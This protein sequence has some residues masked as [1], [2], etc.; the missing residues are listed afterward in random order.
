MNK[1]QSGD[2]AKNEIPDRVQDAKSNGTNNGRT[3]KISDIFENMTDG[4]VLC[5]V[6][7]NLES[8]Q[9]DFIFID[10]NPAFLKL[11]GLD[12][13]EIIGNTAKELIQKQDSEFIGWIIKLGNI[14]VT[15][16]KQRT[17]ENFSKCLK[18]WFLCRN[19]FTKQGQLV[20]SF[21]DITI[22]K[23]S[24]I[25]LEKS[26]KKYQNIISNLMEGFYAVTTEGILI[27]Y[28]LEFCKILGLDPN[29]NQKGI[30]VPN[31]WREVED[32]D[33][34]LTQLM[35][36]GFIQNYKVNGKKLNG[37]LVIFEVN[38]RII[39]DESGNPERIEGTFLDV[40]A[41]ENAITALRENEEKYRLLFENMNEGFLLH[42]IIADKH[43]NDFNFLEMNPACERIMGINRTRTLGQRISEITQEFPW[44]EICQRV[45][46]N[47][48]S[49]SIEKYSPTL[50]K[51]FRIS[52]FQPKPGQVAAIFSDVTSKKRTEEELKKNQERLQFALSGSGVSYWEWFAETG[53]IFFDDSWAERLGYSAKER[54]FNYTWWTENL[55]PE[56]VPIAKKAIKDYVTGKNTRYELEYRMKTKTGEW[57]WVW[58][59]GICVEWEGKKPLRFLG[60]HKDITESKRIEEDLHKS[61]HNLL[62][63]QRIA[64]IG[65][66]TW[67]SDND[68]V[69]C[70]NE[71]IRILG[72]QPGK[73]ALKLAQIMKQIHPD[74]QKHVQTKLQESIEKG[75]PYDTQFRI[76]WDDE[77]IHF[78]HGI[79]QVRPSE[80]GKTRLLSGVGQDITEQKKA[81]NALK[82]SESLLNEVGKIA[83]IGGWEFNPDTGAGTWTAET[84]RIHDLDPKEPTSAQKGLTFYPPFYKERIEKAIGEAI[85]K[86]IPWDVELVLISAK[87]I[88]KWVRSIGHP[89]IKDDKVIKLTG[90]F[91]DITERKEIEEEL[92]KHQ[93]RLEE[94]VKERTIE[95][96]EK[97]EELR[98]S[99]YKLAEVNQAL[100]SFTYSVSHDLRAPLRHIGGFAK[101]LQN[102]LEK[103]I[104]DPKYYFSKIF[105]ASKRM[106]EMIDDLLGFSRIGRS[107]LVKTDIDLNKL[108]AE[109]ITEMKTEIQDRKINWQI[110]NLPVVQGDLNLFKLVFEN[111]ITNAVK[112]TIYK[113]EAQIEIGY[114]KLNDQS[115]ELYIKDNGAGF[116]SDYSHKLFNVFQRLHSD[117]EFEGT[118]IGLANVKK[119]IERHGGAVRATGKTNEG[120]TFFL[121]LPAKEK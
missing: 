1:S 89:T 53:E 21:I 23:K 52:A 78:I 84:A 45:A 91:Q 93:E 6:I 100:E 112:F 120:A 63:A 79:G 30:K 27:E 26:K 44:T 65:S 3:N 71:M 117:D 11:L 67:N 62:E 58:A 69:I 111:L 61:E 83:K 7:P 115:I 36:N 94:L 98:Q 54:D 119:I 20:F 64:H 99:N 10:T 19:F 39:K 37:E 116:D 114:N 33:K 86:K 92:I 101:L 48:K 76:V 40:T 35:Q 42:E 9:N 72:Y 96:E 70:S 82:E 29:K 51:W 13:N 74:D 43:S 113:E 5:E 17:V 8:N 95:L 108:I 75:I 46:V 118:G 90:S 81:E 80:D 12:Y 18:Q 47:G 97:N 104:K 66:W 24:D 15:E 105:E 25:K 41:R 57:I 68:E 28:N 34:Y 38:A 50:N 14:A 106:Q 110:T 2:N 102:E 103:P 107:E 88:R 31:F 32:R 16:K 109:I 85:T 4:F 121:I 87:G 60:T 22:L 56:S 73:N 59:A 77:S 55:H 49:E